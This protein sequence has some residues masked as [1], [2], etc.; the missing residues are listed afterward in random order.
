MQKFL[1]RSDQ[2]FTLSAPRSCK[3]NSQLR[4][5]EN[6][7]KYNT[8]RMESEAHT[9]R[10]SA[11]QSLARDDR[12]WSS[13]CTSKSNRSTAPASRDRR[14]VDDGLE[15]SELDE[16]RE[17]LEAHHQEILGDLVH[18]T[19]EEMNTRELNLIIGT[20]PFSSKFLKC[21]Y[22]EIRK[23]QRASHHRQ[24]TPGPPSRAAARET[25]TPSDRFSPSIGSPVP[26]RSTRTNGKHNS[27]VD[28]SRDD[29][30]MFNKLMR[31]K[32][33][34]KVDRSNIHGWGVYAMENI[35]FGQFIIE[36][37]GE[38]IREKVA[39][40]RE[41]EYVKQGIECSYFFALGHDQIVDATKEG[42]DARLSTT[43][44]CPTAPQK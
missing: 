13:F 28:G 29:A 23:R 32:T 20:L 11:D 12:S 24:E 14:R 43:V 33:N 19:F 10:D 3:T 16:G 39:D 30:V 37:V 2:C 8:F 9:K 17:F 21:A 31:K 38:I 42:N 15:S 4:L 34:I 18:K 26:L 41:I 1:R 27:I 35:S 6:E 7:S 36:Y 22:T 25:K 44:A 5:I 40:L